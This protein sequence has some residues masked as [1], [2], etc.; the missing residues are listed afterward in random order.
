ML[1]DMLER[2]NPFMA[3]MAARNQ[4][5]DAFFYD[6]LALSPLDLAGLNPWIVQEGGIIVVSPGHDKKPIRYHRHALEFIVE[7]RGR[8]DQRRPVEALVVA[9][10]GSSILGTAALARSIA[11]YYD[12]GV[13]GII[14]GYGLVDLMA[15]GMSGWYFYGGVDQMRYEM[16]Q[17]YAGMRELYERM[18]GR[19]KLFTELFK[20]PEFLLDEYV[21]ADGDTRCLNE[22]LLVRYLHTVEPKLPLRL[23]VGHSKGALLISSAL[24]HI[25]N[26]LMSIG[27]NAAYLAG[28]LAMRR[29]AVVTFGAVVDLPAMLIKPE[30]Q[31][32]FLGSFDMLGR[33]N[34]RT[35][36]GH[37]AD[38]VTWIPAASHYL[39]PWLW[40]HLDVRDTL[41][42]H[43]PSLPTFDEKS[44]S[45]VDQRQDQVAQPR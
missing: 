21:P 12:I 18:F 8:A 23:L 33:M 36:R 45:T 37:I 26:E 4:W 44:D 14:S 10:V 30:N 28:D 39:N 40:Y 2:N 20:V 3:L 16:E 34:S 22:I 42:K 6:T 43:L 9:G 17:G 5:I 11:D 7:E 27:E 25:N 32:Q 31:H 13:A 29:L 24:N 41:A 1:M 19:Q 35:F 38:G 15:E